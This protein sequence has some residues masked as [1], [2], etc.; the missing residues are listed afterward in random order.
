MEDSVKTLNAHQILILISF[1]LTAT[2]G[3]VTQS[4]PVMATIQNPAAVAA[5]GSLTDEKGSIG[6]S[7]VASIENG[8]VEEVFNSIDQLSLAFEPTDLL[9]QIAELPPGQFPEDKPEGGIEVGDVL[10]A[11]NPDLVALIQS[12]SDEITTNVGLALT[13]IS[14]EGFSK[15]KVS[16][17]LP[18]VINAKVLG[19]SWSFGVNWSGSAKSFVVA[20]FI[21]FDPQQALNFLQNNYNGLPVTDPETYDLPGDIGITIDPAGQASFQVNNDSLL[22]TKATETTVVNAGYSRN[23]WSDDHGGLYL[24]VEANS[25]QMRLARVDLRLGD[26][27]DSDEIFDSIR[28]ANFISDNGIDFDVGILWA[29]ENYQVGATVRN[30]N[31]ASFEFPGA[32]ESIYSD[33]DIIDFLRQDRIFTMERQLTLEGS[34]F[35]ENRRWIINVAY[36]ANEVPD[37]MGDDYQWATVS[38]GYVTDSWWLPGIRASYRQNLAG[39]KLAYVGVGATI[40]K[41]VNVDVTSTLDTVNIDGHKLPQGLMASLGFQ[42]N[43]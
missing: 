34:L 43:F 17:D 31:E 19:G 23:I 38:G 36:D 10:D 42:V 37:Q 1:C 14:S 7:V 8:D 27:T 15:A 22:L 26:I 5:D 13:T 9:S 40:L 28:N 4:K 6:L 2:T 39:S 12:V 32:N 35:S 24:G 30:I 41:V 16:A 3:C 18:I 11:I 20:D 29:S 25:Y 33:L 21:D